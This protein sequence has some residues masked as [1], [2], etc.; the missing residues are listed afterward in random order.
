MARTAFITDRFPDAKI[1]IWK[2]TPENSARPERGI[3]YS[4]SA[5]VFSLIMDLKQLLGGSFSASFVDGVNDVE[6]ISFRRGINM[7]RC[8][9]RAAPVGESSVVRLLHL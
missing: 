9:Y 6:T 2:S 3:P 8:H 7:I 1:L 4:L 5:S